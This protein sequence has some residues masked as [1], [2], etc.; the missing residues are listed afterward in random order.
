MAEP[1][2]RAD[3]TR[4]GGTTARTADV[5]LRRGTRTRDLEGRGVAV[6]T[7]G[8]AV[9]VDGANAVRL[10]AAVRPVLESGVDPDA[11]LAAVPPAGRAV[12][13]GLLDRLAEHDLL[14]EVEDAPPEVPA[15]TLDHL[16]SITRRPH[17]AARAL[18]AARLRVRYTGSREV[19]EAAA[20][21]LAQAGFTPLPDVVRAGA[22]DA[23][24]GAGA[25]TGATVVERQDGDAW[26]P[27]AFVAGTGDRRLVGPRDQDATPELLA[28]ALA[29]AD[30]RPVPLP[31][32]DF[33]SVTIKQPDSIRNPS[34]PMQL[35]WKG[36]CR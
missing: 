29:W 34:T 27:V 24:A 28:D 30:A 31:K 26:V 5:R 16:E 2:Q 15:A 11:L 18:L 13:A 22:G 23:W 8:A 20:T 1:A 14:R 9:V 12:V 6:S 25:T 32:R 7:G 35:Y 21:N 17:A 10:W 36:E 3:G 4:D 33:G 19:A